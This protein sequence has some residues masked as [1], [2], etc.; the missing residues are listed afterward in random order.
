[1]QRCLTESS[2]TEIL[3]DQ[4]FEKQSVASRLL[5][6]QAAQWYED[7]KSLIFQCQKLTKRFQRRGTE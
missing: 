5:H 3:L 4:L 6:M 7:D 1:M 2:I